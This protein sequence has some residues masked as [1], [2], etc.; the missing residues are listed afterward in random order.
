MRR[1]ARSL[2]HVFNE[3]GIVKPPAE[4]AAQLTNGET[5][6][7]EM[8]EELRDASTGEPPWVLFI[9]DQAEELA[10]LSGTTDRMAFLDLLHS[11]VNSSPGVQGSGVLSDCP[12]HPWVIPRVLRDRAGSRA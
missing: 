6:L 4:M 8:V 12:V 3:L 11:T 9:V 5:A 7:V 1:L 2:A 10:T